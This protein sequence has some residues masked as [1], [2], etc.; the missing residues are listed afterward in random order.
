[1]NRSDMDERAV[2]RATLSLLAGL[3]L[4]A[5]HVPNSGS[6]AGDKMA[7]IKQGARRK[8]DGVRAGVPDLVVIDRDGRVGFLEIKEPGEEKIDPEQVWW[9]DELRRRGVPW[10]LVNTPDGS[11]AAL[12]EWGWRS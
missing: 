9:R 2:Q 11:L 3:G 10:A 6:L 1:M 7:R 4:Q 8:A 12:R 5:F